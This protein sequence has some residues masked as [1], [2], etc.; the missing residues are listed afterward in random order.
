VSELLADG[1]SVGAGVPASLA[2]VDGDGLAKSSPGD[3]PDADGAT[4]SEVAGPD[5]DGSLT[6]PGEVGVALRV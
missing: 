6:P 2:E 5:A 1:R 3:P 4:G